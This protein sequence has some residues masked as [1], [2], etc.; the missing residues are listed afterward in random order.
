MLHMAAVKALRDSAPPDVVVDDLAHVLPWAS[1]LF[2][3]VPTVAFFRHLHAR[4]IRGQV[5][6]PASTMLALLERNYKKFY[7]DTTFI[8]ESMQSIDDLALLGVSREN[9]V[10][11]PPGVDTQLFRPGT[12]R[13]P[14]SL[15]YF[16]GLRHYKRAEDA[17]R[18]FAGFRALGLPGILSVTGEGPCRSHM[19]TVA[20]ELGIEDQV[21][22]LGKISTEALVELLAGATVNIHCSL[23]EGWGLSVMEAAASGVP[24]V[25]YDAPGIRESV[26]SGETGILVKDGSIAALA[27]GLVQIARDPQ[28]WRIPARAYAE[29]YSWDVTADKWERV[30]N[31]SL[32]ALGG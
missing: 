10:R 17:I 32:K 19:H 28:R 8:T 25:A 9:C 11:I 20:R 16:G 24:T 5:R 26:I 7:A 2:S 6:W 21:L 1:P 12:A 14:P 30:L 23:A 22:F 31:G 27:E 4:T 29:S 15:V 13:A 18:A 3:A